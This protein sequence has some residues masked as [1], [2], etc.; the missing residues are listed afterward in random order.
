MTAH[1]FTVTRI[2]IISEARLRLVKKYQ[3]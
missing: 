3:G 2:S 1:M